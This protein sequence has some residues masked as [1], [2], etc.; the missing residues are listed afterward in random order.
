VAF[1]IACAQQRLTG[2]VL[3]SQVFEFELQRLQQKAVTANATLA[4]ERRFGVQLC[5][6]ILLHVIGVLL[7]GVVTDFTI[8][9]SAKDEEG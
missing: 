8:N 1:A 7:V 3:R 5:L 2:T 9:L 4:R 6:E